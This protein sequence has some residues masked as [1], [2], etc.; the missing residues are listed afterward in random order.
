VELSGCVRRF[1][2]D[3][4]IPE[5]AE[6]YHRVALF[7]PDSQGVRDRHRKGAAFESRRAGR[8]IQAD[9]LSMRSHIRAGYPPQGKKAGQ[10]ILI[11]EI[12]GRTAVKMPLL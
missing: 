4:C 12:F 6:L 7:F 9:R 1:P 10:G 2:N 3:L 11:K 8:E 5:A